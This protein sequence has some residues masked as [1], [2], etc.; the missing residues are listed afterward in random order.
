MDIR[1]SWGLLFIFIAAPPVVLLPTIVLFIRGSLSRESWRGLWALNP[2]HGL[3]KQILFWFVMLTPAVYF[4]LFG[5]MAWSDGY[6]LSLDSEGFKKFIEISTLPVAILSL[7]IALTA[8]VTYLHSTAQTARQIEKNKH[9]LFYLHRNQFVAYYDQ[10]GPTKFPGGLKVS[11]RINPRVHSRLFTG[12]AKDGTPTVKEEI[13]LRRIADLKIARRCLIRVMKETPSPSSYILYLIFCRRVYRLIDFFTIGDL[14]AILD[15][16]SG[17]VKTRDRRKSRILGRSTNLSVDSFR[18][19]EN[20]LTS[21]ME[22]SGYASG[23]D[24]LPIGRRE[25]DEIIEINKNKRVIECFA[26]FVRVSNNVRM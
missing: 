22:F 24:K 2:D 26:E 4:F 10:V 8:L 18:C 9:E 7:A 12:G 11:Y 21:A 19:V 14:E 15:K 17:K 6:V 16:Q 23:L 5:S 20:Y 13:F 25:F 3:E 1:E